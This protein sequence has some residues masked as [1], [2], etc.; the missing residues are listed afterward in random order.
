M[1]NIM[2]IGAASVALLCIGQAMAADS[3]ITYD[4]QPTCEVRDLDGI[5]FTTSSPGDPSLTVAR[6]ELFT[7]ICDDPNG[8]GIT[9]TTTN[10]GLLNSDASSLVNYFATVQGVGINFPF[11]TTNGTPTTSPNFPQA[12]SAILADPNNSNNVSLAVRAT[13]PFTFSGT[14]TDTLSIEITG[15]P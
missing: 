4:I 8:A 2:P 13:E 15:N 5:V 3:T 10:G 1:R 12:A 11:L 9:L 14:Y 7:L 6:S